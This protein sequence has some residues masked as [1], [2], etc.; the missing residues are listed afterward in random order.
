MW[1]WFKLWYY[2]CR[3]TC[4]APT[5]PPITCQ[6]IPS[7]CSQIN[8]STGI[9]RDCIAA[10]TSVAAQTYSD[11]CVFDLLQT[12]DPSIE[13]RSL[14]VFVDR[15]RDF[16]TG[17]SLLTN[18]RSALNCRE[19]IY[20]K[21]NSEIQSISVVYLDCN[22]SI[23]W[24]TTN[25]FLNEGKIY[26]PIF[27]LWPIGHGWFFLASGRMPS[28]AT[29]KIQFKLKALAHPNNFWWSK[30]LFFVVGHKWRHVRI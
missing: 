9:F 13:C 10:M 4:P 6:L 12:C 17:T 8:N 25:A 23:L 28:N 29:A 26:F 7:R 16:M 5:Q 30:S 14:E 19:L 15:C 18:W 27:L 1:L 20:F 21:H 24:L 11:D 3:S 22:R 2:S